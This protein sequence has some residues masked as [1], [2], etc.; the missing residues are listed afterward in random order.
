MADLTDAML[1][2]RRRDSEHKHALV[3]AALQAAVESGTHPTIAG[4]ARAARVG[5]KFIYDHPDLRAAIELSALHATQH[6]SNGLVAA[7][8]ITGAPFAS[9]S[10]TLAP[11]TNA[12][13]PSS[14]DLRLSEAEGERLLVDG[15]IPD[16]I[17]AGV[18]DRQLKEQVLQLERQLRT[19]RDELDT[20]NEEL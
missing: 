13:E 11:K 6:H 9:T 1:C 8:R 19:I 14:E 5:R 2:H 10:R 3:V 17:V 16:E 12:S 7:A 20:T 18:A 4:I 15:H